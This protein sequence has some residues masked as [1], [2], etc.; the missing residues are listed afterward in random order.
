MKTGMKLA[1]VFALIW[2]VSVAPIAMAI[3]ASPV[4][5]LI[6]DPV[7][8]VQSVSGDGDRELYQGRLRIYM[9][10]PVSRYTD[11][12]NDNYGY[13]MLDWAG[14]TVT[15]SINDGAVFTYQVQWDASSS[16]FSV[17]PDNLVA[18]AVVFNSTAHAQYSDPPSGS[19]FFAYWADAAAQAAPG[20][21]GQDFKSVDFTHT[22]F[23]EEL[24]QK[25]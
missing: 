14:P 25:P 16:G 8:M 2:V 23:I 20:V 1:I 7:E 21:P 6:G 17:D 4:P 10:E 9:S 5:K 22:V 11:L 24:T 12:Y 13:G 19:P 15:L 18:Q 3:E